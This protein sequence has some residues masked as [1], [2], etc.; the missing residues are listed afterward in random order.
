M[1]K[2]LLGI[3]VLAFTTGCEIPPIERPMFEKLSPEKT[4]IHFSN[5]VQ[6]TETW[7]I[8]EYLYY[9]NGGGVGAGDLNGDGWTDLVFTGNEGPDRVYFNQ[10]NFQ[11]T[12]IE[13]PDSEHWSTGVSLVDINGDGWLDI[14]ICQL[15]GYKDQ[16]GRNRLYVNQGDGSFLEQA[17]SWGLGLSGFNQQAAFFDYDLDGDLDLYLL[18]HSVHDASNYGPS[19]LR[20]QSDSLAG[21]RLFRNEGDHFVD[22]TRQAGIYSGRIGFGLGVA[23]GDLDANG[24]P[25]IY[26]GNDF[27]ENDY[28]YL[29]QGDGTFREVIAEAMGHTST[30]SMGVTISDLD[31]DGRLDVFSLDM[32]PW[33]E[34]IRKASVGA[35][36]YEIQEFKRSFGYHYQFPRNAFQWNRGTNEDGIPQF[37]ERACLDGVQATDWSWSVLTPDLD[38]DGRK[39]IWITNGIERRPND[40][41]YLKYISNEA[42]QS[43]ASN[44]EFIRQMPSGE[45]PNRVFRQNYL[46]EWEQ[47]GSAW[48]LDDPGCTQ[49]AVYADLDNDGDWDLVTNNLNRTAS[50]FQ[51]QGDQKGIGVELRQPGTNPFAFGASVQLVAGEKRYHQT[52][53]PVQGWQSCVSPRLLFGGMHPTAVDWVEVQWPDGALQRV[54]PP[55][56]TGIWLIERESS[57]VSTPTSER[58]IP[59]FQKSEGLDWTHQEND[60]KDFAVERLLPYQLSHVG[61]A[62]AQG[63]VNGDGRV[64]IYLGGGPGQ[65]GQL[66]IQQPSGSFKPVFQT[67]EQFI[68]QEETAAVLWDAN[69]DGLLDLVVGCGNGEVAASRSSLCDHLW[70]QQVDG[71]WEQATLPSLCELHTSVLVP[72]DY[73]GD[74][75]LDLFIGGRSV[76]GSYG[77]APAHQVLLNEGA[78]QWRAIQPAWGK[79]LG[80]VTDACWEATSRKLFIA[81]EWMP[82]VAIPGDGANAKV[83]PLMPP[84]WWQSLHLEDLDQD[85]KLDLLAGNW[86][87]N[88]DLGRPSQ[89]APIRLYAGDLDA[90]GS[91]DPVLAYTRAG[92]E[93]SYLGK[94][95]LKDQIP[96]VQK[97][98]P[99]YQDFAVS[100]LK[101]LLEGLPG[102][103]E[104]T[105]TAATFSSVVI[106]DVLGEKRVEELPAVFQISPRLAWNT[107]DWDGDGQIEI[108]SGGNFQGLTPKLGRQDADLGLWFEVDEDRHFQQKTNRA[109]W[110]RQFVR[111]LASIADKQIL[112]VNNSGRLEWMKY[113]E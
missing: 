60:Y 97:V 67:P 107:T 113:N 53:F 14:H 42:I 56:D 100:S 55:S 71:S 41:D 110:D 19:T 51:N 78:M 63:D 101:D 24:Y 72:F 36:P 103:P 102:Q 47:V 52:L 77:E 34:S 31:D 87:W 4:G 106:W 105:L 44:Q 39:D 12:S 58:E 90:N 28:C 33:E 45:V 48:G 96:L 25:D 82:V 59:P 74:G 32:E 38:M 89:E 22:V 49:G 18:R 9:Y 26:V 68:H 27:H 23:L 6:P 15:G 91:W 84:G 64:D 95:A 98:F 40:L 86:G 16:K 65:A 73:E 8:I 85:G 57:V 69:Q 2:G 62:F 29:N 17:S 93:T 112:V 104:L 11:F 30:F 80:L 81:G 83:E 92:K 66:L 111:H 76:P 109:L 70:L 54:F 37:S 108:L 61:P 7:N 79:S 20:M 43:Q 13:L 50:V 35:D 75:D 3:L 21:D 10:G 99:T 5:N 88:S 1:R 46:F 94:D